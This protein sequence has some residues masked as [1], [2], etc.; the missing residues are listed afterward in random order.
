ML[1]ILH[2]ENVAVIEKTDIEFE[3]GLN[4]LTGETGA[5][6]SIVIDALGA[7]L[8]S[9]TSRE[10]IRTGSQSALITAV[11][12]DDNT[13]SWREKNGIES[14]DGHLVLMRRITS[15]GKSTCRVNGC[16]VTV[17]QLKELGEE[18]L[19]IHGQNDG[20]ILM[21]EGSHIYYLDSFGKLSKELAEYAEV[22][23]EYK[24]VCK[25]MQELEMDES[26]KARRI[27]NLRYQIQELQNA[28]IK[29]GETEEKT[30]RRDLLKNSEKLISAVNSA[31][32]ALYGGERSDG[33]IALIEEAESEVNSA[34]RYSDEFNELETRLADLRYNAEDIAETLRDFKDSLDFSPREYD[35]LEDRLSLLHRLS[36]KYG[37]SEED[38]LSYLEKCENEL[39]DIEYSSEKLEKLE[40]EAAKLEEKAKKCAKV[41]SDNRKKA[42]KTLKERIETELSQLSMPGVKFEVCFEDIELSKKGT[43]NVSF[44][45]SANAGEA[46]G[47]ISKIASGGELS[48]IMLAMKN[49]LAENDDV[50]AMV[51]D[52]IDTGVS[53]I[54]AQRVGEKLWELSEKKQVICITHLPQ[55]ASMADTQ[56]YIMKT[57]KDGRTFTEITKLDNEGRKTEIA[58]LTGG[59]VVTEL[60]LSSAAEQIEAAKK[61]KNNSKC[62]K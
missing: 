38:M 40:K 53:G 11:F 52:E 48:R 7:V 20:R 22:Y 17:A 54:A 47:K 33:A 50:G 42:A 55:I 15:D 27:D 62:R 18:L 51:F 45:M 46:L 3:N 1:Q 10:I 41:L 21:D 2:I 8:G 56:F 5:G 25:K 59:D 43:D 26:E 60:T 36:R 61:Y 37:P 4:V 9:R 44:K 29:P 12:T 31:Y 30:K 23:S 24:A 34:S 6:K 35:E 28:D 32:S 58:R 39:S 49:A 14:E 19:N 13:A 57:G 16:P